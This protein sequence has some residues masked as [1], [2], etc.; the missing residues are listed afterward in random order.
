VREVAVIGRPS[1]EWGETVTAVVVAERPVSS[2]D[3]RAHA[4]EQLAS[5]KVPKRIE[6]I[7]QLPRNALGKIVRGD[8]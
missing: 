5:Y 3:L 7:E 1:E 4:A 6:F 8:L 2:D